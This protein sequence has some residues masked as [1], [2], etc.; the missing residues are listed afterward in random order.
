MSLVGTMPKKAEASRL[1]DDPVHVVHGQLFSIRDCAVKAIDAAY[2]ENL[3]Q[4]ARDYEEQA[5]QLIHSYDKRV[6]IRVS[7]VLDRQRMKYLVICAGCM[8][9]SALLAFL[10]SIRTKESW[11][12]LVLIALTI[13]LAAASAIM[14]S[15]T[16][17]RKRKILYHPG[18][19][20]SRTAK[21]ESGI[22]TD[23]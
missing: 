20:T 4:T 7:K 19:R 6:Y 23:L 18:S 10:Y 9:L 8:V 15:L 12:L 17:W 11:G 14:A 22:K 3:L 1:S 5:R 2:D 16:T 21:E 13:L